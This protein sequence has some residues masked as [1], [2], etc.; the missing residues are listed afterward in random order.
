MIDQAKKRTAVEEFVEANDALRQGAAQIVIIRPKFYTIGLVNID[1]YIKFMD[2]NREKVISSIEYD[3]LQ[4][5][6]NVT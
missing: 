3:L 6:R 4:Q 2:L 5:E 1:F